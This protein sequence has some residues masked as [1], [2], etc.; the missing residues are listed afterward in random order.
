MLIGLP[1][2]GLRCNGYSLARRVLLDRAGR[3]LDD[4]GVAGAHHRSATSCWGRRV[5]YAPAMVALRGDVD[6]RAVAHITGGGIPGNLVR[7]LPDGGDAVVERG[8]WEEPRIFAEI[9]RRG[10]VGDDEMEHVFN[11]GLGMLVVVP[12]DDAA[13]TL[14]ALR[15]SGHAAVEVGHLAPASGPGREV[16]LG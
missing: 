15:R 12:P 3:G 2:P 7:V 13:R 11:L 5:I 1:S 16:H 4:A 6:V 8:A 10:E 14:A 9:Q